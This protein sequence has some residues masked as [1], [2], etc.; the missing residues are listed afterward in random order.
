MVLKDLC[1]SVKNET[2]MRFYSDRLTPCGV[3]S[4]ISRRVT[5][6]ERLDHLCMTEVAWKW[7]P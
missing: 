4:I 3:V 7:Q 2:V 5:W 1:A 6:V